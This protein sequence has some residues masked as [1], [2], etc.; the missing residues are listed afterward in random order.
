MNIG[1][2]VQRYGEEISGG[3]ELHCRLIAEHLS[4]KHHVEV[5]TTCARDYVSWRNDYRSGSE[6][7]RGVKVHRF[8]VKRSRNIRKFID[9]QNLVFSEDQP[10]EIQEKWIEENGPYC[11]RLLKSIVK[12]TDIDAWIL[13]SY[14]YWTTYQALK[15]LAPR[16]YLV[17]TAEHDPALHMT[18]FKQSFQRPRAIIYNSNEEM[19]LIH[20]IAGNQAVPGDI[21]GVGL[22]DI[23][24]VS[25]DML[26]ESLRFNEP[27]VIYVGRIDKNKGCDHLFRYMSRFWIE[28]RKNIRLVLIGTA[29]IP[30]PEHPNI[31]HLG[32]VSETEKYAAIAG[33]RV[34]IMPSQYESL[35]MVLLEAWRVEKPVLV[36]RRCEVLEG[37]C[38]R[39]N[40]G[41][42]YGTYE[43]FAQALNF[44]VENSQIALRIGQQGNSY[45]SKNYS[46]DVIEDKY[47]R[48]LAL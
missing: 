6:Q 37:Q 41:L 45:Y 20:K 38:L 36:N 28:Q 9:I 26:P 2:I 16:S 24:E 1:F 4:K 15:I 25:G 14:R 34:L 18:V 13:F 40:G 21:V 11:P 10:V 3:A 32:F 17:P 8:P 5:F 22:A 44:L 12:R 47:Q 39:S 35:S 29:V 7:I 27:Y 23:P 30:I 43:E 31:M 46:W 19:H 42:A 48:I 33:S